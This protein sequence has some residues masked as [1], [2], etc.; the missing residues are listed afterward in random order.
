MKMAGKR[1]KTRTLAFIVGGVVGVVGGLLMAP[2]PGKETREQLK[3]RAEEL[4]EECEDKYGDQC[5]SARSMAFG[6][7]EDLKSK[8]DEAREKLLSGVE[9]ATQAVKEKLNSKIDTVEDMTT[10]ANL[11]NEEKT[12][13]Q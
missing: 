4:M 13:M 11:N 12:E 8:I 7:G 9:S 2:R 6:R 3:K 5:G 10:D 1:K